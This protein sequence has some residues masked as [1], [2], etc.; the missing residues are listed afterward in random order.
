[1]SMRWLGTA[2]VGNVLLADFSST[3]WSAVAEARCQA[4]VAGSCSAVDPTS[5]PSS[6]SRP[7]RP[8]RRRLEVAA[9]LVIVGLGGRT[10]VVE[11]ELFAGNVDRDVAAMALPLLR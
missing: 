9:G 5:S 2:L 4:L 7:A 3:R 8:D 1:M 11:A 10:R 6:V